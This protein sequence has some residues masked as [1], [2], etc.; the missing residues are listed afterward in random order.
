MTMNKEAERIINLATEQIGYKETPENITKYAAEISQKW[1]DFYNGSKGDGKTW[2]CAW[3]DIFVDWL[4]LH[5]FGEANALYMLCQPKKSAGAGCK[6]SRQ[7]YEREGQLF[8]EPKPGD[9]IFF[10]PIANSNH[11]GIVTKV[12][13]GRVY[14][15]EGNSGNAV[16][17][18]S[19][20]LNNSKIN[21]YGRPRWTAESVQ[22]P[23]PVK[24]PTP[25]PTP[26][27]ATTPAT[28]KP[29]ISDTYYTVKKG[30]TL[31][32]IAGMFKTTVPE[33]QAIN[34]IANVNL[35]YPGQMILLPKGKTDPAATTETPRTF[36]GRVVTKS[37]PLNVRAG[38][39][40]KYSVTRQ[41]A[42][43]STVELFRTNYNGWYKLTNGAGFVSANY[44]VE[45]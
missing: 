7:Y 21:G 9:Q 18:H 22:T 27:P 34:K 13:D 19:Y 31:S 14:T 10:G 29:N 37:L 20:A 38:A 40:T 11:T 35:I 12:E 3:C 23:G 15:V 17:A 1:P 26:A 28:T 36:I 16:K 42:K 2:G 41:L 33:L 6:F 30:D 45:A 5:E 39:G 32:K 4:F 43:G 24:D 44:I 8:K 25:A